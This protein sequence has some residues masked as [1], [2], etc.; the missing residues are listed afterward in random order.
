MFLDPGRQEEQEIRFARNDHRRVSSGNIMTDNI[1]SGANIPALE[2]S[3]I[4]VLCTANVCR[5]PMATA[6]LAR[7]LAGLGVTVPVRSAGMLSDGAEP[8]HPEVVSVMT[9]Y[10][11]EIAAHRSRVARAGRPGPGQPGAGDVPGESPVRRGHRARR[12]GRVRSRSRRS[13][14]AVSGSGRARSVSRSPPGWRASTR[15]GSAASLLGG[16][17]ADDVAD[18]AGA[19]LRAYAN[20]VSLLDQLVTRL[21]ETWLGAC[22]VSPLPDA[23]RVGTIGRPRVGSGDRE[24][25]HSEAGRRGWD[26]GLR[27]GTRVRRPGPGAAR[28]NRRPGPGR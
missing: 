8:P 15:G 2:R 28:A 7:R 4:L 21:A 25:T 16:S 12:S 10:G 11:I 1:D 20:T 5:S 18:P 26:V 27:R 14:G 24:N 3:G 13:S 19:T 22:G 23:P 6:L 9:S 17:A